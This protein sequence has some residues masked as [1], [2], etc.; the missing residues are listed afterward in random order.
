M[1]LTFT[2]NKIIDENINIKYFRIR[3]RVESLSVSESENCRICFR[4]PFC[5]CKKFVGGILEIHQFNLKYITEYITQ[6]N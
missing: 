5:E 2:E 6:L 4:K 1:E 3:L